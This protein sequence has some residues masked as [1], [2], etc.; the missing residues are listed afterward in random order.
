MN[1]ILAYMGVYGPL[2]NLMIYTLV[3]IFN[4]LNVEISLTYFIMS[5]FLQVVSPI[6]NHILKKLINQ[7][8]PNGTKNIDKYEKLLD[9]GSLGMPSGHAQM[10]SSIITLAYYSNFPFYIICVMILL[11]IISLIQRFTYKKHTISQ[12]FFGMTIGFILTH[13]YWYFILKPLK[14]KFKNK[15]K[16]KDK[17]VKNSGG[18][19]HTA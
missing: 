9:K 3:E 18:R 7:P 2:L 17:N 19:I 11:L 15:N 1:K 13:V 12:L 10:H 6:I 8:R 16:L 5:L 4:I 14:I